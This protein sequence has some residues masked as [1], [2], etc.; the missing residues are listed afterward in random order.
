MDEKQFE[1]LYNE[2][3]DEA[4]SVLGPHIASMIK[5]YINEKYSVRLSDTYNNPRAL[6][7]ALHSAIDGASRVIQRRMLRILYGKIGIEPDFVMTENF[8][9]KILDAKEIFEKKNNYSGP[10]QQ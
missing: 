1:K 9:R 3:I 6:T 7:E 2:S 10:Q 8:E 5:F 4:L